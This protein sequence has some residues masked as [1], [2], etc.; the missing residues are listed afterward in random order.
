MKIPI[1]KD[2]SI[3]ELHDPLQV[4]RKTKR[5]DDFKNT[6]NCQNRQ[7][8]SSKHAYQGRISVKALAPTPTIPCDVNNKM[9]R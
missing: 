8:Y 1:A 4:E 5:K 9:W 7:K 3:P 2:K 6:I